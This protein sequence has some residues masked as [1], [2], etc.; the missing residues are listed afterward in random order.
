MSNKKGITVYCHFSFK[1]TKQHPG[2]AFLATAFYLDFEGKKLLE[3]KVVLKKLWEDHQFISAIQSYENALRQI[4]E[5]QGALIGKGVDTVLLVTD[6]STLAGWIEDH[7]KNKKYTSYMNK[8]VEQYRVG[9]PREI[10]LQ[11]GLCEPRDYE[12]SYKYCQ[13]RYVDDNSHKVMKSE[14]GKNVINFNKENNTYKTISDIIDSD[15][16]IPEIVL[17]DSNK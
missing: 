1:R 5:W 2:K 11:V 17:G 9:A 4:S 3:K 14:Q 10:M 16:S 6:N 15:L 12:K 13:D 8:A 7:N